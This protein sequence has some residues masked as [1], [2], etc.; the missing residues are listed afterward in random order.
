MS[1]KLTVP[2]I[3]RR[4]T[5]QLVAEHLTARIGERALPP[6]APLPSERELVEAFR[7][8]RSSVREALRML[9]SRGLIESQGHGT[10]VVAAPRNPFTAVDDRDALRR[11]LATLS[12]RDRTVLALRY[13]AD[14]SEAETADL[15]GLS[16]GTIKSIAS[17]ALRRLRAGIQERRERAAPEREEV[18]S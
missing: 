3:D 10:F 5:Y 9:E 1:D 18:V 13:S 11:L 4:K 12:A 14:L 17:R 16:V 2:P 7:V 15:M 6:G 8:G